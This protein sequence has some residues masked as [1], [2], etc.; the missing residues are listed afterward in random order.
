MASSMIQSNHV[1]V[2]IRLQMSENMSGLSDSL[3]CQYGETY[4]A[5]VIDGAV[6][7]NETLMAGVIRHCRRLVDFRLKPNQRLYFDKS[8]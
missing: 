3:F 2:I 5:F 7:S 6:E 1:N 8:Y 4:D